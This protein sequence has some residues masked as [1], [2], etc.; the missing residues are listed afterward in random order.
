MN[1]MAKVSTFTRAQSRV[2]EKRDHQIRQQKSTVTLHLSGGQAES[3]WEV[4]GH[5]NPDTDR[6][7]ERSQPH[8]IWGKMAPRGGNRK[9][10]GLRGNRKMGAGSWRWRGGG[11]GEQGWLKEGRQDTVVVGMAP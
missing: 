1:E 9:C 4:W 7:D 6:N 11:R 5:F 2:R 8:M 3:E 10:K